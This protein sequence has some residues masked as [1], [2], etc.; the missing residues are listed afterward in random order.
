[1]ISIAR[2]ISLVFFPTGENPTDVDLNNPNYFKGALF[3]FILGAV[4]LIIGIVM[5][6]T[7]PYSE[8]FQYHLKTKTHSVDTD[9]VLD[10]ETIKNIGVN[11]RSDTLL[12]NSP[13]A[14]TESKMDSLGHL[15]KIHNQVI[16]TGYGLAMLYIQTFCVFPAVLL[17][18]QMNFISTDS[19]EVWFIISLY[20][21]GDTISRFT[22]E[23]KVILTE[24]TTLLAVM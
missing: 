16:I 1:M 17:I 15:C 19:W 12:E 14:R 6:V 22:A 4:T 5:L 18:G 7:V 3:Y 9:I 10:R 11:N 23:W 2:A 8:Y 24:K 21:L 20:N 13:R